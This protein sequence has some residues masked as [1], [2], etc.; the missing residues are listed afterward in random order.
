LAFAVAAHLEPEIL[1][2]DEVLAVGDSE[3]Q[4]K[5]LGK[6]EDVTQKGRTVLFVSH[7]LPTIRSLCPSGMLLNHGKLIKIGHIDEVIDMYL[8]DIFTEHVTTEKIKY[9]HPDLKI[10]Q[11]LINDSPINTIKIR[12]N[13]L[14]I[15]IQMDLYK[16]TAFELDVHIKKFGQMIASYA[17]FVNNEV[18]IFNPGNYRLTYEIDISRIKTGNYTMDLFFTD[19]FVSWTAIIENSINLD[20]YNY[21][22]HTFLNTPTL[23][24]GFVLLKGTC[25]IENIL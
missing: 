25:K 20:I 24:W 9:F 17:N 3:F 4:K 10:N 14:R 22:H 15:Y 23:K 21:D 18:R 6:M 12:N 7:N 8:A 2:I 13:I 5:C 11:L 16:K 1:I 19:P